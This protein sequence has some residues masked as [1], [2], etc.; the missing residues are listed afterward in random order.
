MEIHRPK[1]IR[2][3]HEFWIEIGTIVFS[4]L[5]ALGL[6]QLV[7][8]WHEQAAAHEAL[9]SIKQEVADDFAR[10]DRR[11]G[12]QSCIDTRLDQ[13]E[14]LLQAAETPGYVAPTWIGRPPW[15]EADSNR[16]QAAVQAGRVSL[17][18][19]EDQA[20]LSAVYE[21]FRGVNDQEDAEQRD[22]AQLR[23]L[24]RDPHP[25]SALLAQLRLALQDAR[26]QN[27]AIRVSLG[28]DREIAAPLHLPRSQ[29]VFS[30]QPAS[31]S[32]CLPLT[33]S[34]ADGVRLSGGGRWGE[35]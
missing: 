18:G 14:A 23:A 25:S 28:Q 15:W 7:T 32:A 1:V 21:D 33:T 4:I 35:P 2:N 29:D 19:Q 8:Q 9:K 6:E 31:R 22:W 13:V 5:I 3:W 10:F 30:F 27:W 12:L 11:A 34:R 16:W 20:V 24:E 17:F 26:V